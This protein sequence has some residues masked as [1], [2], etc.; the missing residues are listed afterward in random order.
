MIAPR[1]F[2]IVSVM[3]TCATVA[4]C[5]SIGAPF[6]DEPIGTL[7][8]GVQDREQVLQLFGAPQ[9]RNTQLQFHPKGCSERWSYTYSPSIGDASSYRMQ[10]LAVDFN[11]FGRVCDVN[12][13]DLRQLPVP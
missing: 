3:A 2:R 9:S 13:M 11:V 6:P 8:V 12:Y 4:G 7:Q 1:Y 5:V 10:V